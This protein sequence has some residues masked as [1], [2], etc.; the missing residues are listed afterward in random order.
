M[1]ASLL[2]YGKV[3]TR[4]SQVYW[5]RNAPVALPA[6]IIARFKG[7]VMAITGY[8]VDQVV[9]D[10][11]SSKTNSRDSETTDKSIPIYNA[12]NHHYFGWLQGADS[13]MYKLD[14]P[15]HAPNPTW[16]A[17]RDLPSA[18]TNG[19]YPTNIVFKENPGGEYRKSYHGYPRGYA[20]LLHSPTGTSVEHSH[21]YTHTLSH[22]SLHPHTQSLHMILQ[23]HPTLTHPYTYTLIPCRV[24]NGADANRYAQQELHRD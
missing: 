6:D 9:S 5:T 11:P 3:E 18:S 7:K 24:C 23:V 21:P 8:E 14:K 22:T 10:D 12:Y 17:V 4:Y 2:R 15:I 13:E 20:Q 19:G 1:L 16:W